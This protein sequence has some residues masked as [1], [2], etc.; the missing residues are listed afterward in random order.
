MQREASDMGFKAEDESDPNSTPKLTLSKLP[1]CKA[2]DR[3]MQTPPLRP[4]ASIPFQWE[5]APGKPRSTLT[6]PARCLELPP[7]ML[8]EEAKISI[9]GRSL[10]LAC[11]FSFRKGMKRSGATNLGSERKLSIR[12]QS[13]GDIFRSEDI[14]TRVRRSRRRSFFSF[15]SIYFKLHI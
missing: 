1:F 2:R 11:T 5:E 15:I 10:S 3:H 4:S 9:M 6:P 7:R 12:S 14:V 13:L 8:Q